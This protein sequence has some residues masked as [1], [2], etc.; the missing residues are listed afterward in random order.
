MATAYGA[1]LL[2]LLSLV[3]LCYIYYLFAFSTHSLR[4]LVHTYFFIVVKAKRCL[5]HSSSFLC[6]YIHTYVYMHAVLAALNLIFHNL[7]FVFIFSA[8]SAAFTIFHLS[9][10]STELSVHQQQTLVRSSHFYRLC[11]FL[12]TCR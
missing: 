2:V 5:V 11:R 12:F 3:F 9:I 1:T 6:A 10:V 7:F 4:Q 8:F